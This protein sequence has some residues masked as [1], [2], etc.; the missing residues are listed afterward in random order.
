MAR[1]SD[2]AHDLADDLTWLVTDGPDR[3]Q[4]S[5]HKSSQPRLPSGTRLPTPSGQRLALPWVAPHHDYPVIKQLSF[6]LS[7]PTD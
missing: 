4:L 2:I 7:P 1:Y 6:G 5:S 3:P